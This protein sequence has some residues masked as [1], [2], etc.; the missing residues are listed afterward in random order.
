MTLAA[1]GG[2]SSSD[3]NNTDSTPPD[4]GAPDA[5]GGGSD[6]S[7][8]G[9]GDT[10]PG[11][12]DTD[13]GNGDTD[14]GNGDTVPGNGDSD[15]GNGDTDPG[16]GDTD[17]GN[18]DSDPGNGDTD[19]GNEDTDPGNGDTDPGNGDTDPGNGD[20]DPGNGDTDPGNGDDDGGTLGVTT[21]EGSVV[22]DSM[23]SVSGQLVTSSEALTIQEDVFKGTYG[24]LSVQTSGAWEYMLD[25]ERSDPLS[26]GE[27]QQEVFT[28][29]T[30]EPDISTT[31]TISV[32]GADDA[33]KVGTGSGTVVIGRTQ[34]ASGSI[35][36]TD[37][38]G[39]DLQFI[40]Q[41][42]EGSFG[43]LDIKEDGSWTYTLNTDA[44]VSTSA[45]EDFTVSVEDL[46]GVVVETTSVTITI[47]SVEVTRRD[48]VFVLV[49]FSNDDVTDEISLQELESIAF[50][51]QDS[52][53]EVMK[54]N[55]LNQ[56]EFIRDRDGDGNMDVYVAEIDFDTSASC[57]NSY[58]GQPAR[59]STAWAGAADEYISSQYS[60]DTN[61]W[62][63]RVYLFPNQTQRSCGWSGLATVG[64]VNS[65]WNS[66]CWAY[67]NS[68]SVT[69]IGHE[70]GHNIGLSHSS[71]DTDNNGAIDSEYGDE[72]S[73][74]GN[75]R[76]A[77]TIPVAQRDYLNWYDAYPDYSSQVNSDTQVTLQATQHT[78]VELSETGMPQF[79]VVNA[80]NSRNQQAASYY[81]S[82]HE[83]HPITNPS[84]PASW[85]RPAGGYWEGALK[86]HY[87][88]ENDR[89]SVFVEG[90][91]E[92]G[93]SFTDVSAGVSITFISRDRE[94]ETA[95]VEVTYQ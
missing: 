57:Q 86:I 27:V 48:I 4:A 83:A 50:D 19:P 39:P 61:D 10:D 77:R 78:A 55:S 67:A 6:N 75:A 95:V 80:P 2:G 13:P 91:Q 71:T 70:L 62:D 68:H 42:Q 33:A 17:P 45:Q 92:P 11:N 56:F 37:V 38:D 73:M 20:T 14:P 31:V 88:L 12:G 65:S 35:S 81:V 7:D 43:N 87:L 60:V 32:T 3:D 28:V 1:C 53:N 82:Y 49:N 15:P 22:E 72:G 89:Q 9:N 63:H 41:E 40:A 76:G 26:E 46:S 52:I 5:P 59:G 30:S 79:M 44:S 84:Q 51:D 34:T 18:G 93:D 85:R 74:M 94:A 24:D 8:S 21:G 58:Y 47:T 36:I 69:V 29:M 66:S 54:A 25:G 16:N 23:T 90:L 64:C